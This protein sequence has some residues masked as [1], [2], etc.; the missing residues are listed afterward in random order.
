MVY[1]YIISSIMAYAYTIYIY[2]FS[3]INGRCVILLN[4]FYSTT[5]WQFVIR[6]AAMY[7]ICTWYVTMRS[8]VRCNTYHFGIAIAHHL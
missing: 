4:Y 5:D 6:N 8:D 1:P 7:I 3:R 2:G